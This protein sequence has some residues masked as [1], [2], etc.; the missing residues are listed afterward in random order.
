MRLHADGLAA[1]LLEAR[2]RSRRAWLSLQSGVA[3]SRA[4]R[5]GE[6][7]VQLFRV[8]ALGG[9]AFR[10]W[11]RRVVVRRAFGKLAA[12]P[13]RSA[14]IRR[15]QVC[16][17]A[18]RRNSAAA[19]ADANAQ[20]AASSMRRALRRLV[21][22][23]ALQA[24]RRAACATVSASRRRRALRA[25][26]ARC[27]KVA[28]RTR[29]ARAVSRVARERAQ[30]AALVQWTALV[31][32]SRGAQ[33]CGERVR[34]SLCLARWASHSARVRALRADGVRRVREARSSLQ[35]TSAQR[36]VLA[37]RDVAVRACV[38]R[39]QQGEAQRHAER[40]RRE[41]AFEAWRTWLHSVR[42]AHWAAE[43]A[44]QWCA[45][46]RRR[47]AV[48][49]WRAWCD[50]RRR[51]RVRGAALEMRRTAERL[52]RCWRAWRA[53]LRATR[54]HARLEATAR[55]W[56]R[57]DLWRRGIRELLRGGASARAQRAESVAS[58][59]ERSALK[60][61]ILWRAKVRLRRPRG[62]ERQRE[63]ARVEA[64]AAVAVAAAARP[65]AL[66]AAE[67]RRGAAH[68]AAPAKAQAR[69]RPPRRR[70]FGSQLQ[71][72]VP[73]SRQL[74]RSTASLQPR[75]LATRPPP[76]LR[77]PRAPLPFPSTRSAAS[78]VPVQ[79][80]QHRDA[81]R[82]ALKVQ[83]EDGDAVATAVPPATSAA[84]PFGVRHD[85]AAAA[86]GA[87]APQ[88][89]EGVE[90]VETGDT[91]KLALEAELAVIS[92][93]LR[94]WGRRKER[95]AADNAARARVLAQLDDIA[96]RRGVESADGM[97]STLLRR[98]ASTLEQRVLR[99]KVWLKEHRR[100]LQLIRARLRELHA[101][102]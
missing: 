101:G 26:L 44:A 43:R 50:R 35:A 24:E 72:T 53:A 25:A 28:A 2:S 92:S 61:G 38:E 63:R 83:R 91:S 17:A 29:A 36:L 19:A 15:W 74:H 6:A 12:P 16:A 7:L 37:W 1:L 88:V 56:R 85:T 80:P 94:E 70:E 48:L 86:P 78:V 62:W 4:E 13:Q 64:A 3:A 100:E 39:L 84:S 20:R 99:S 10:H 46:R 18:L 47:S 8:H 51:R 90:A 22:F 11:A 32:A 87:P 33:R 102:R 79:R 5:R 55:C 41:R 21:S 93:M 96:A 76:L 27:Q 42:A 67:T 30:R 57:E 71:N 65:A 81:N 34:A 97:E 98:E 9:G 69:R 49:A 60:C 77:A 40:R 59:A 89:V 45:A 82:L 66:P 75:V 52:Q 54:D 95:V 68:A 14:S 23:A 58:R 73:R 31:V